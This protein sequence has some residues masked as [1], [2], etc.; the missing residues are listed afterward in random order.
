MTLEA[1]RQLD[2]AWGTDDAPLWAEVAGPLL[3]LGLLYRDAIHVWTALAVDISP[4][5]GAH[6]LTL[7]SPVVALRG[8]RFEVVARFG[9]FVFG[10]GAVELLTPF[11]NRPLWVSAFIAAQCAVLLADPLAWGINRARSTHYSST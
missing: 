10:C 6:D 5:L 9:A 1:L 8:H 11:T 7:S 3:V 4:E 2:A